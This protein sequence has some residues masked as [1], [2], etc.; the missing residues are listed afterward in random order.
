MALATQ[1][2]GSADAGGRIATIMRPTRGIG[3]AL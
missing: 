3:W 2:P 1:P